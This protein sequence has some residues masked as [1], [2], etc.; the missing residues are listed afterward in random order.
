[1]RKAHA[2]IV[3]GYFDN[4]PRTDEDYEA[5]SL[6]SLPPPPPS[7]F[8]LSLPTQEIFD[9]AICLQPMDFEADVAK[10]K[11]SLISHM[12]IVR[13]IVCRL[14]GTR[15]MHVVHLSWPLAPQR[16]CP[17]P[18]ARSAEELFTTS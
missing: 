5:P 8:P 9:C 6:P 11:V 14:A 1:M 4:L 12:I 3:R 10:S 17:A 18:A 13:I 7:T 2:A 15:C 16:H